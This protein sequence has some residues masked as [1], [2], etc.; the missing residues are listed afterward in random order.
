MGCEC[1][2]LTM[3]TFPDPTAGSSILNE[4]AE[5][6]EE[7]E[8]EQGEDSTPTDTFVTHLYPGDCPNIM[9]AMKALITSFVERPT[10]QGEVKSKQRGYC[11]LQ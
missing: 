2:F 9:T 4:V 10:I 3:H 6:L 7:D 11:M 1:A 5:A 8:D